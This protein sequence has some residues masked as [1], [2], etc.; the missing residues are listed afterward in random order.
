[1]AYVVYYRVSTKRQGE[2][3]L[4]LEAQKR[5]IGIY[6]DVYDKEG[7]VVA[8][9]TDIKSGSDDNRKGFKQAVELCKEGGHTLLVAKLDRVSRKVSTIALLIEQIDLKVACMP[10]ADKFQIHLYSAMAE[11]ERDF[12]S[13][14]TKSA[15]AA[16]KARGVKIGGASVRAK[17]T[18]KKIYQKLIDRD[19]EYQKIL[20]AFNDKG[21][22]L[23]EIAQR[24]NEMDI[25]TPKGCNQTAM[26]VKRMVD[27]LEIR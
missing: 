6:F 9:F 10:F 20:K 21:L 2:S 14:R 17:Q 3:G 25:K 5:D 4:G 7:E 24:L 27:R 12:I 16:A 26:S 1:M 8:E 18:R 19:S 23:R 22:T 15:M 13:Q 11:Q